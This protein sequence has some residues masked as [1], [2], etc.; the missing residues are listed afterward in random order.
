[1]STLNKD[2]KS[3]ITKR[4]NVEAASILGEAFAKELTAKGFK[5]VRFDRAGYK[6][7]GRVKAFAESA[8]KGGLEF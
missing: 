6:Y 5:M 1:M 4:G 7:H 3:R 8:R 2:I